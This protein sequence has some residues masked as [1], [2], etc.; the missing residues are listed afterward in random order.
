LGIPGGAATAI[1]IGAFLLQGLIPGPRLLIENQ[2]LVYSLLVAELIEEILLLFIGFLAVIFFVKILDIP[3]KIVVPVVTVTCVIG[4]F[5]FRMTLFDSYLLLCFGLLG[6]IMK[7]NGCPVIAV[8]IGIILGP[9]ADAE[10]LR[11]YEMY[12]SD[13]TVFYT[14][15][16][17]LILVILIFSSLF[18][19]PLIAYVH[20]K[21][22]HLKKNRS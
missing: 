15:P 5:S 2:G 8:V 3:T 12:S 16:L 14:R 9:I 17:C 20:T 18:L 19:P 6:W 13:F 10:F 7:I 11:T 22:N 4:V 21:I 1:L